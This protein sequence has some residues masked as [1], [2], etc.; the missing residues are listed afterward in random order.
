MR[1]SFLIIIVCLFTACGNSDTENIQTILVER[2]QFTE[3]L[4]EEG[5]VRSVNATDISIPRISYRY[6]SL[7]IASI[8]DDGEEVSKGDTILVMSPEEVKKSIIDAEQRLEIAKAEYEK[9][10]ATQESEI[11][12]LE[13]D[14]EIAKISQQISQI[15]FD[16]AQFESEIKK[17]EIQLQL[18]T[19]IISLERAGEQIVNKKKIH[20]EELKQKSL[21]MRQLNSTLD[22][23]NGILDQLFVVS[24]IDGI[25]SVKDNWMT[26]N[27]WGPGDQPY[28]GSPII[29]LPDMSQLKTEVKINEVDISKI[30]PGLRVE[31]KSDAYSDTSYTGT[32]THV[33]NLAQPKDRNGKIKIFPVEIVLDGEDNK[34]L[35]GLTVSCK[36]KVQ[37]IPD[38]LF[39]PVECIFE[40]FGINYVYV[41][42]GQ[43]FKRK[44]IVTAE[45]NNDFVIIKEG[46][47][48]ADEVALQD[49]FLNKEEVSQ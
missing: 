7:K 46:V 8:A 6:G 26:G 9:L 10:K 36:I 30:K 37:V 42:T 11:E 35:P 3:E 38:V 39:L 20:I 40:E 34:L 15:N 41:K 25:V 45:Q 14:L 18:E 16:N 47:S 4:T 2:G 28:G 13:A 29:D 23:A 1:N 21:N 49:P 22:E 24:P 12:D 44:D 48:E 19:A 33:A 31:I 5:T 27:K 32:V 17:R 43:G